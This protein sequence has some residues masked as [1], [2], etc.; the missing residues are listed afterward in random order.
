MA[1]KENVITKTED[2]IQWFLPKIDKFPRNYK[3]LFGD[4]IVEIQLDLLEQLIEAYF[5][6]EKVEH[7]RA[8]NVEIEKLRHLIK[9]CVGMK[10]LSIDQYEFASQGLNDIGPGLT[11]RSANYTSGSALWSGPPSSSN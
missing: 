5:K 7:L 10:F 4:R 1:A 6:K 2:F 9:I 3:F 8:A 11:C